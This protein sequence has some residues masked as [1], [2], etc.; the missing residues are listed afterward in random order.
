MNRTSVLATLLTTAT[1]VAMPAAAMAAD[2]SS[3]GIYLRADVRPFC[4][5]QSELGESPAL[6][7]D[8]AAELGSV[9]EVCNTPGGYNIDVQLINVASGTLVHGADV[10]TLD[11][12]GHARIQW[13]TARAR[14]APWRLTQAALRQED[15]PIYLRVSISPI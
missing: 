6:F 9:R 14:T 2:G 11:S 12:D 4:R 5:I 8:G 3:V 7:I 13:G 1:L 15:A 10:Q